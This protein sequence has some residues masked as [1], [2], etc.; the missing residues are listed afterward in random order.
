LTQ[1]APVVD[2]IRNNLRLLS[3]AAQTRVQTLIQSRCGGTASLIRN[4]LLL[5]P[6]W[7][8]FGRLKLIGKIIF[9]AVLYYFVIQPG[10]VYVAAGEYAVLVVTYGIVAAILFFVQRHKQLKVPLNILKSN[11]DSFKE[12]AVNYVHENQAPHLFN[13]SPAYHTIGISSA[14]ANVED[15]SFYA[16]GDRPRVQ[17]G[18][19][20][21][22]IGNV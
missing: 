18:A 6:L 14:S 3:K 1:L 7:R 12:V 21:L 5:M 8:L 2:N 9:V 17:P 15:R 4:A 13:G 10:L 22:T 20:L 16:G 11:A 19:F